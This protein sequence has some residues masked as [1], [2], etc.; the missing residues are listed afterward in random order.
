GNLV[1]ISGTQMLSQQVVL[2][3][4]QSIQAVPTTVVPLPAAAIAPKEPINVDLPITAEV[5][6]GGILVLGIIFWLVRRN[7]SKKEKLADKA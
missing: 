4:P 7:S 2:Y 3:E 5:L 6:T 1:M